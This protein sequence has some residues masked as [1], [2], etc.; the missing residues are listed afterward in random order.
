MQYLVQYRPLIYSK[1]GRQAIQK[2]GLPPF[3]DAS[4]RREPDFQSEAP[5][6]TALCRAG[7]FAPNLNIGDRITYI[8]VG[9]KYPPL[10]QSHSRLVAV[11]EVAHRFESHE[12]AAQWYR[13]Q[14]YD[15]PSNCMVDGNSPKPLDA[16]G[17]P[18]NIYKHISK[19]IGIIRA[20]NN[21]YQ[22]RSDNF[23]VFLACKASFLELNRPPI[24][25]E[26]LSLSILGRTTPSIQNYKILS[27]EQ[28]EAIK[29]VA[30][31]FIQANNQQESAL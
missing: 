15:F 24:F 5:S 4:I 30:A 28:F 22:D 29:L 25:S 7:K 3:I 11:L 23:G 21:F 8:T 14:G 12:E 13:S 27:S 16:A 19:P 9:Y 26:E 2:F 1:E 20:W 10:K 6:I 18:P 17:K 31:Q